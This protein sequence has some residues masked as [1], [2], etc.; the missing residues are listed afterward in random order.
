MV[1][2]FT[3]I[4][5]KGEEVQN[6]PLIESF[7]DIT[8]MLFSRLNAEQELRFRSTIVENIYDS[9]VTTDTQFK[10]TY[11][12]SAAEK[13]YGYSPEELWG[14]TPDIFNAEPMS[15]EIQQALYETVSSGEVYENT[16]INRR[17]DGSLFYCE[18]KVKPI[19]DGS[20][21]IISFVGVQRDITERKEMEDALRINQ[22][23]F[24]Q[25]QAF[26]RAGNWE[27]DIQS[28]KLYWSPE[29]ETL[30]GLDEGSFG[31]T[32]E[33]FVSFIHPDDRE[34]VAEVNKPI[35]DLKEG[36]T[37]NYEHRIVTQSGDVLWV[38]E[39]AGV[40]RD[41]EGNPVKI[42][43]FIL[44]ITAN[45]QAEQEI[46]EAKEQYHSLIKNI[47]GITYRCKMD[48]DWTML[49][50]SDAVADVCGYPAE[51][52]LNNA[53]RSYESVIHP[54]DRKHVEDSI[55]AAIKENR[56]WDIEYRI[57]HK[58]GGIRWVQERGNG[59]LDESGG[60]A[61][62]DGF[63]LDITERKKSEEAFLQLQQNQ[64]ILLDNIQTQ[65]WYLTDET[66]Y[67][68]VNKAH[69]DFNGVK[70]EDLAFKNLYDI[71]PKEIVDVCKQSNSEVFSSK[72]TVCT[73]EWVP[74]V[75][76]EKR[77]ISITKSP[78]LRDDGTVE[79]VVCSA[80][81]IT[82][83][84]RAEEALRESEEKLT[85]LVQNL[86]T[87]IV[88][89]APDTHILIAN[90]QASALL[91]LS[92]DQM[93]GKTAIDPAWKFLRDDGSTL[94]LDEYPI[95]CVVNTLTPMVD[96]I[97]GINRPKTIDLVWVQVAAYPEFDASGS[98]MQVVVTFFD[99]T[100]RKQAEDEIRK[101]SQAVEQSPA[102]VVI[103]DPQGTIEYVNPKFTQ[104]TG[105][106]LEE[107]IGQNPRILKSGEQSAEVYAELWKTIRSGKEW[108]GEFHNKKKN[109]ELFWESALITS[110]SNEKGEI[111]HYLAVK[112][113][114]TE[115]K[116]NEEE[117]IIAK[118]KAEESDR[119]KSAFL[120]NM[121]HEIRTPMNGILG[122][123]DL[124]K[125]PGLTGEE[126][127]E[128]IAII[129]KS[130]QRML[131]IINDIVDISKIEAGLMELRLSESNIN[132]QIE[133]IHT[134]FKPEA[135]AKGI[136]LTFINSITRN[137]A[138]LTIDREKVYA[139]LTNLVKN[140]I[141]YTHSGKIELGCARKGGVMEIYV[142]D[143]GIGIPKDRQEAIF[144]RFIQADIANRMAYQGAGL[145]LAIT[146]AYVEM[147]GG[148]I[149]VES[150]EGK[151]ST[152]Y[153]T[154]PCNSLPEKEN[155]DLEHEFA[156]VKADIRELKILV[157]EDDLISEK[158]FDKTLKL[159]SKEL[160]KARTGI[161][162][163]E[164]CRK[165]PDI[166]LV[167]MDIRLPEMDGYEATKLIRVF[168][169]DV[170][171]IAQTAYGLTGAQEKAIASGC[172]D[173]IAKPINKMKLQAMIQKH[174]S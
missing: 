15:Q 54:D 122:F 111:M 66:T 168:N 74:H 162:A 63:I 42:N 24:S 143:T 10:I 125:E 129:K 32:F 151:G 141:K 75:S 29:C 23:R 86:N 41:H 154:L 44:D 28:G 101:L 85:R 56:H 84:K 14:K 109:G 51:E 102:S 157:V 120:A 138:T 37:L 134:F 166:D 21:K 43:G 25:A 126:Q 106:T 16:S 113:D 31:G 158:L 133:Y 53:V 170:I 19:T 61:W 17:K 3:L 89:H 13:L 169:K 159:S 146:K 2:D 40:V 167:L 72:K 144:E 172:N 155:A 55:H 20:G 33:D 39:S 107:A 116:K 60:I 11:I 48:K 127:Q 47:P 112:E 130:G 82:E 70:I 46:S 96:K 6:L 71:F 88:V 131:N 165:N 77:L 83:R 136:T 68:A 156:V 8:G 91:G 110:I 153:F 115:R 38:R 114:I 80:A 121:S 36:K 26:A 152:F 149:W 147:L 98:L 78:K 5:N 148:K 92:I 142:K 81:D 94:P 67:G 69:A 58:S 104:I 87:G 164:A 139:I 35:T 27:Y 132:E 4:F 99:I 123:A 50:M 9:V 1:G 95:N 65:I 49:F 59:I 174:F 161:E 18:Y 128:Y 173:Y 100:K 12:N 124:L 79:Y 135:E 160:L 22:Q 145:G 30:F 90:E 150:E 118:E 34:Y 52:F 97:I 103:T 163:V 119:L 108:K 105:Y 57:V 7:S 140:A 64:K 73:E 117:L 93:M 137:D 171:I 45:K 76:G 62:L